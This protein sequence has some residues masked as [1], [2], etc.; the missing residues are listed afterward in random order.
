MFE[1]FLNF[2]ATVCQ[3]WRKASCTFC[4]LSYRLCLCRG[5]GE[6]G[7]TRKEIEGDTKGEGRDKMSSNGGDGRVVVM[8]RGNQRVV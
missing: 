4:S 7:R 6:G 5:E 3:N 2:A 1:L 8:M